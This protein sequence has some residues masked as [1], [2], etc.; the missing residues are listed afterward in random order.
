[1]ARQGPRQ[2]LGV[3]HS[4]GANRGQ[5]ASE[6]GSRIPGLLLL[7]RPPRTGDTHDAEQR[8]TARGGH[9]GGGGGHR[10]RRGLTG[11]PHGAGRRRTD[12][13]RTGCGILED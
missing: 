10:R 2:T 3:G 7:P 9:G 5:S 12:R 1:M 11:R 13:L 4:R 8:R 6:A